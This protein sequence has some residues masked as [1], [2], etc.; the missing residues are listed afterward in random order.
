MTRLAPLFLVLGSLVTASAGAVHL[1]PAEQKILD[2]TNEARKQNE[3]APL[4]PSAILCK[5]AQ[6]NSENMAKQ[7]KMEH[8]LDGKTPLQRLR[9]AGYAY[10]RAYENIAAGDADVSLEALMKAWLA[11]KGHRENILNAVCTEIGLGIAKDKKGQVYYT[12]LFGKQK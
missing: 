9:A 10:S 2:L 1:S 7:G 12:Q 8:N 11:S 5:V 3:L 6:A 4:K